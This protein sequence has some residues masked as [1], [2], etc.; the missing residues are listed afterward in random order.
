MGFA[1]LRTTGKGGKP[2]SHEMEVV[3]AALSRRAL[4]R[5]TLARQLLLERVRMPAVAAVDRVVGLQ[6]QVPLV[7]YTALWNRLADFDPNELS[8]LLEDRSVARLPLMRATIHLVT[9]AD[10]LSL[11]PLQQPVL[12][13]TFKGTV[14]SKR[15]GEYDVP[16]ILDHGRTLL[17]QRPRTRAELG[18]LQAERWTG[19]DAEALGMAT[20]YLLPVLQ[21]TPRGLW[22]RRGQAAW[23]LVDEWLGTELR[24]D[25]PVEELVRRYLGAFGPASVM[26]IQAWCGLTRLREVTDRMGGRLRRLRTEAGAELLDVPDGPLPNPDTPVPVR[27]LPEYDNSTLGYAD[28]SRILPP[29]ADFTLL[30]GGPGGHVGSLLVDGFVSALWALTRSGD[31]AALR[32]TPAVRLPS[33]C[34]EA[35]HAEGAELLDFLAPGAESTVQL[36]R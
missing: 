22:G 10:A 18:R 26:D 11:R 29:D 20:T 30:Q 4:N 2:R 3:I 24:E 19:V 36:D 35:I 9:A 17:A 1:T 16:D 7:P 14:W 5:S 23:A 6:A 13:R 8:Q 12:A 21:P 31:R 28:R 27:F 25:Y 32:I 33:S 15:L 34:I